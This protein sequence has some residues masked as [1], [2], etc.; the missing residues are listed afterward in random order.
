MEKISRMSTLM[1]N[2]LKLLFLLCV[3]EMIKKG[4][5]KALSDFPFS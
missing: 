1:M 5:S 4:R 3:W 2:L